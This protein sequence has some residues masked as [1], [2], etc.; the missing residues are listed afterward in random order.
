MKCGVH[1]AL[2]MS[3]W[4][5]DV[6]PHLERAAGLGFDGAELSLLGMDHATVA[7]LAERAGRLGLELTC[8]TGLAPQQDVSSAD[9]EV[10][11]TGIT[12]LEQ[13]VRTVHALG[14]ELLSGVIYAPW[15]QRLQRD[16]EGRWGR[17]V[18]ALAQVAPLAADLG[19][20]LGIEAINRYETDLVTT[21][22]LAARMARDV[23]HPVVGVLL[24]TYHMNIEEKDVGAAIRAAGEH[25]FHL[26][27]VENDRGVPGSGH[28]PW[29]EVTA[30]LAAIGYDGWATL[31][32]FVLSDR[33]VS[34][35]LTVWRPIEPDPDEAARA[36]LAFLRE[37]FA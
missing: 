11:R 20:R 15:A 19:V 16:R 26:H 1:I 23:G 27:V 5:E 9:P 34:P 35:D 10:R 4:S 3:S 13:A 22:E 6:G 33:E 7:R 36:G 17:S 28:V 2:W 21:A 37:R 30:A 32:M 25:L 12:A 31:E 24:D 29:H 14:S 18:D 8:T